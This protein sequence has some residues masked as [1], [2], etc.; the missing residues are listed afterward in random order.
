MGR[1][2]AIFLLLCF[3][4]VQFG[5]GSARRGEPIAGPLDIGSPQVARGQ[6][7]FMA[8]CHQCHPG[9]EAGVGPALNNK[10]A[11]AFLMK[12]QVRHGLGAMPRFSTEHI[13]DAEL[14]ALIAYLLTLRH[15]RWGRPDGDQR[16]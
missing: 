8:H 11:P 12:Y 14:D 5:C 6:E 16:A 2:S 9:G 15:H 13:D 3:V 10:P 4:L 1:L 7:V